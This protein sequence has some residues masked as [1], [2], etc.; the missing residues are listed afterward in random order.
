M[1]SAGVKQLL[2]TTHQGIVTRLAFL[3]SQMA[4]CRT[5]VTSSRLLLLVLGQSCVVLCW[6]ALKKPLGST[7]NRMVSG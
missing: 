5:L 4:G 1:Q 6:R 7:R 3:L 2:F